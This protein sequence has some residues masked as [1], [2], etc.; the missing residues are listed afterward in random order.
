MSEPTEVEYGSTRSEKDEH[1]PFQDRESGFALGFL[2]SL[3][4]LECLV[5]FLNCGSR[6]GG[7]C[8]GLPHQRRTIGS[9]NADS[10]YDHQRNCDEAIDS[11]RPAKAEPS[12]I[13]QLVVD[14]RPDHA[15]KRRASNGQTGSQSAMLGEVQCQS[16]HA[17]MVI[18]S[19][20]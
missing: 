15:A 10:H 5:V 7:L 20:A 2:L 12:V 8:F 9:P 18:I 16:G 6:W 3:L 13:E 11:H 4:L 14:N 1:R 19:F 17:S